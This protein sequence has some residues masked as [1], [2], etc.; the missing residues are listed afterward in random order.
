MFF[1]TTEE[2]RSIAE[3][4]RFVLVGF[5]AFGPHEVSMWQSKTPRDP[6]RSAEDGTGSMKRKE[7]F[8]R[9]SASE[10]KTSPKISP[11]KV[12]WDALG[13]DHEGEKVEREHSDDSKGEEGPK[14]T[15][16]FNWDDLDE[17]EGDDEDGQEE[18][19]GEGMFDYLDALM[20]DEEDEEDMDDETRKM[21][22]QI[23]LKILSALQ[24]EAEEEVQFRQTQ[25]KN[26]E[27]KNQ[28]KAASQEPKKEG[29]ISKFLHSSRAKEKSKPKLEM[30]ARVGRPG[31]SHDNPVVPPHVVHFIHDIWLK[32]HPLPPKP[33][34]QGFLQKAESLSQMK[35][36]QRKWCVVAGQ[37]LCY[38]ERFGD[39]EPQGSIPFVS[40]K[41]ISNV[42]RSPEVGDVYFSI[43]ITLK[44]HSQL[45]FCALS[46]KEQNDWTRIL[47][48]ACSRSPRVD[49]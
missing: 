10:A 29:K 40:I 7:Y 49:G 45:F 33:L 9:P 27:E 30:D 16:K 15:S 20:S 25:Q 47:Q 3:K 32:D 34:K 17:P 8:D 6:K 13:S 36:S 23:K 43:E 44:D 41:S 31:S 18:K 4:Q 42:A 24:D 2:S 5:D 21:S 48:G 22:E 26:K 37:D 11:K 39:P 38:Y 35:H 46:K 28:E 19:E 12:D 14:P 1:A